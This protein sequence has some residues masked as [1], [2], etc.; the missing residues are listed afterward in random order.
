MK[1][2]IMNKKY[3]IIFC[4][5]SFSCC[6]M[7]N[8]EETSNKHSL[9]LEDEIKHYQSKIIA[10]TM[11]ESVSWQDQMATLKAVIEEL[12][13]VIHNKDAELNAAHLV[14]GTFK[15]NAQD[16][17][18]EIFRLQQREAQILHLQQELDKK[19]VYIRSLCETVVELQAYK[20]T[21][22]DITRRRKAELEQRKIEERPQ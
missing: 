9:T 3:T 15:K 1:G 10:Q 19:T 8:D 13:E 18:K 5:I 17:E 7:E 11:P 2:I 12:K 14:I 22:Q 21:T 20:T 4:I 6:A 16:N